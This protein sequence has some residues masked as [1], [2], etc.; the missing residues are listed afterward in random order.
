MTNDLDQ[1]VPAQMHDI[2]DKIRWRI[3]GVQ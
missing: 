3:M 2:R 1:F